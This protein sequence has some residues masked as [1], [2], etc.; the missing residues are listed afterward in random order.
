ME[1]LR[2]TQSK[3][4]I[5][6]DRACAPE[7]RPGTTSELHTACSGAVHQSFCHP[8]DPSAI[9]KA[10]ALP[11]IAIPSLQAPQFR[12]GKAPMTKLTAFSLGISLTHCNPINSLN[13][14][15]KEI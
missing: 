3:D 11:S 8:S 15:F 4:E 9:K 10:S 2:L 13:G 5:S 1:S 6:W 12:W 7:H 14:C